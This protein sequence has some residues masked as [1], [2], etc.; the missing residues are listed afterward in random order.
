VGNH[1]NVVNV[2]GRSRYSVVEGGDE[3]AKAVNLKGA[4]QLTVDAEEKCPPRIW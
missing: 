1:L 4:W 3:S 2:I